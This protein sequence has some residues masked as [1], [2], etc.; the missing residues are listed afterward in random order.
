MLYYH[1]AVRDKSTLAVSDDERAAYQWIQEKT[2]ENAVFIEA[3]DAVRVPVLANR[4]DY[5]G[6]AVYAN[7]WGYP[8]GEM[9][10]RH[11][12]RDHTFSPAGLSDADAARLR[13]LQRPV[14]V[15]SDADTI[16][17]A[18]LQ[19]AFKAGSVSVWQLSK[20]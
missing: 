7:N 8:T 5:W 4:D 17:L 1:Q 13:E 15:I 11:A 16:G 10:A 19:S 6:T 12:I 14:F 2:P 20:D 9:F 18:H 3:G